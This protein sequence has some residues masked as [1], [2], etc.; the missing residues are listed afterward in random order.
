[1]SKSSVHFN[2]YRQ[3]KSSVDTRPILHTFKHWGIEKDYNIAIQSIYQLEPF[4]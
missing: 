2:T 1:M 3:E 4:N